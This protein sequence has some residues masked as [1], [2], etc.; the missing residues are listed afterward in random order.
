MHT[1][2]FRRSLTQRSPGS[3]CWEHAESQRDPRG[4]QPLPAMPI[5]LSLWKSLYLRKLVVC[6]CLAT[7]SCPTLCDPIDCSLPG[8]SVHGIFPGKN[9]GV[10]CHYL[11]Q[12][13]FPNQGS[14]PGLLHCRRILYQLSHGLASNPSSPPIRSILQLPSEVLSA[15]KAAR[16]LPPVCPPPPPPPPSLGHGLTIPGTST[17][18]MG[19]PQ[20]I[21]VH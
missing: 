20:P 9:T 19:L 7:Q 18:A 21:R 6:A 5:G 11:L 10:G 12:E 2:E 17:I 3:T 1:P 14:N 15:P 16:F 4:S 8:S 13:I